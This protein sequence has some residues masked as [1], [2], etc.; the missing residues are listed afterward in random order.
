M[1]NKLYETVK[2]IAD[3]YSGTDPEH[4]QLVRDVA[5]D[6]LVQNAQPTPR[7]RTWIEWFCGYPDPVTTKNMIMGQLKGW[8]LY[9]IERLKAYMDDPMYVPNGNYM[10]SVIWCAYTLMDLLGDSDQL[11]YVHPDTRIRLLREAEKTAEP[12][13]QSA[14]SVTQDA[15]ATKCCGGVCKKKTTEPTS[16]STSGADDTSDRLIMQSSIDM[17]MFG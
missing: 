16:A 13:E 2:Q 11:R 17:A 1:T 15:P 5:R 12:T 6:W 4:I 14:Q 10:E 9:H 3:G 7:R 8:Q